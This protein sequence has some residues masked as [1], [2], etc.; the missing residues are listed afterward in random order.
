MTVKSPVR[1]S[2]FSAQLETNFQKLGC[3]LAGC[4]PRSIAKEVL[5]ET[6]LREHILKRVAQEVNQE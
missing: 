6:T 4:D 2:T 3:A 1:M 5:S